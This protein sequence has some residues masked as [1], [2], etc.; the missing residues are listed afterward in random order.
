[1]KIE[2]NCAKCGQNHFN[3][4]DGFA[5]HAVVTCNDCGHR[6]GTMAEVKERVAAEVLRRS[7]AHA[8]G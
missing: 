6:V 2:L 1:M 8:F 7:L 4:A 3:L 5:D